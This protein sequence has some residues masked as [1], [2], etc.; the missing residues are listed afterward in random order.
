MGKGRSKRSR[1]NDGKRGV[2]VEVPDNLSASEREGYLKSIGAAPQGR[3]GGGIF[4]TDDRGRE[5]SDAAGKIEDLENRNEDLKTENGRLSRE[6]KGTKT[7]LETA[8]RELDTANSRISELSADL[9]SKRL[10]ISGINETADNLKKENSRLKDRCAGLQ[11]K[12]DEDSG[13]EER[14]GSLLADA[15]AKDARIRSLEEEL[16]ATGSERDS[17]KAELNSLKAS[18]SSPKDSAKVSRPRADTLRSDIF[19]DGNYDIRL[20][21]DRSYMTIRRDDEGKASCWNREIRIP[22]LETYLEFEGETDWESEI[23]DGTVRINLGR[24]A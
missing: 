20:A 2:E 21:P 18:M 8:K 17:L 6:L 5:L 23:S 1:S 3:V 15:D 14:I 9:E 12:L 10:S 24:E 19:E 16:T 22:K 13:L 7:D 4:N 11:K